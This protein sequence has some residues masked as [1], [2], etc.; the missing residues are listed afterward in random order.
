MAEWQ[1]KKLKSTGGDAGEGF[2]DRMARE[3]Q[4]RW[5]SS[6]EF[7][8]EQEKKEAT[9]ANIDLASATQVTHADIAQEKLSEQGD[10]AA[11]LRSWIADVTGEPLPA[12]SDDLSAELKSGVVL[13]NLLNAI[14]PG[15]VPAVQKSSMPFPQRENIKAFTDGARALGVP[16]HENFETNDL[17]EA[18][19][20]KQV[21][22]CLLSLGRHSEGVPGYDGP[23]LKS[24]TGKDVRSA[25]SSGKVRQ[26]STNL[27]ELIPMGGSPATLA[28]PGSEEWIK[29]QLKAEQE[30][31]V[32]AAAKAEAAAKPLAY[33]EMR[34]FQIKKLLKAAGLPDTGTKAELVARLE[35]RDR[36]MGVAGASPATATT[37]AVPTD[38][39]AVEKLSGHA[40]A[41]RAKRKQGRKPPSRIRAKKIPEGTPT[42]AQA[43]AA[44]PQQQQQPSVVAE[45]EAGAK[46]AGGG[47]SEGDDTVAHIHVGGLEGP[48][49]EDEKKLFDIF[50][51]FGTVLAVTLRRRRASQA[52]G[53][54]KVSWALVA[55]SKAEAAEKAMQGI[56]TL[57]LGPDVVCRTMDVAKAMSSASLKPRRAFPRL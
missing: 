20:M 10:K 12:Q 23:S 15:T 19:N 22:I 14:S 26:L 52:G 17:F 2:D 7:Q 35:E 45:T 28:E 25:T 8:A 57:K 49:V 29:Q 6:A 11:L 40:G 3:K 47:G 36:A 27:K 5:E 54:Q 21:L 32:A 37:A 30:E 34:P 13:C 1:T 44:P 53:K 46:K 42:K 39:P 51:K 16:E 41:G 56:A 18:G 50:R 38:E 43:K 55:F 9:N 4:E 33:S 24:N 31:K 48:A